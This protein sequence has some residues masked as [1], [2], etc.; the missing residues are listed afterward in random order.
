M[1]G[2]NMEGAYMAGAYMAG[3]NM[4]GAYMA[5][6][7]MAGANMEGAN[8]AGADLDGEILKIA[9]LSLMNLKWSVLIT[10]EC[11]RIGCQRHKHE[12][13]AAFDDDE[14]K[15]MASGANEFWRDW[16]EPLMLLC[17]RHKEQAAK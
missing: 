12:E 8:M 14:I 9:P 5:G 7:N 2:A 15:G 3:A 1:A 4:E 17:A 13:W 11:M 10:A 6:A 16:K